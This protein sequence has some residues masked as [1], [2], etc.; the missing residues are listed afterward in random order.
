MNVTI[1]GAARRNNGI[2]EYIA[3]YFH[4]L[5][6][7][8]TAVLGTTM[9]TASKA[10]ERLLRYGIQ[11]S[12]YTDFSRMI[13]EKRPEAVAI[14][15]PSSTHAAYLRGC[16][17]AGVHVFCE[18][19]C[20]PPDPEVPD[21]YLHALFEQ[22]SSRG[23]RIVMNSQWPFSLPFYDA[24]CGRLSPRDVEAFFIHL[25]PL[26]HGKEMITE[27][28]PHALSLLYARLGPGRIADLA[29]REQHLG[30]L[31]EFVYSSSSGE[32]SVMVEMEQEIHQ[33]RSF[34]YGFNGRIVRRVIELGS[35][36]IY[37]TFGNEI[38][39]I[40]DPLELSVGDFMAAVDTGSEPSIHT[41]HILETTS[42]LKEIYSRITIETEG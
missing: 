14:A 42:L 41:G 8:V 34:S 11:A 24:L 16:V 32:C 39:K 29:V 31:V 7:S 26:V 12:P 27:S 13:S 17:D 15:S 25:S 18:K 37:L 2:G 36:T 20:I 19:P 3:R 30:L 6:A 22:A 5:G 4:D 38:L 28:L 40:P 1:I 33:P 10:A 35:Y 21:S 23:I 9:Q